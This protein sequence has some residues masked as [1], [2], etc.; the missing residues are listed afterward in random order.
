VDTPTSEDVTMATVKWNIIGSLNQQLV[1]DLRAGKGLSSGYPVDQEPPAGWLHGPFEYDIKGYG[2]YGYV[3]KK[4]LE[5]G[6]YATKY[7]CFGRDGIDMKKRI[8]HVYSLDGANRKTNHH[9]YRLIH[10]NGNPGARDNS[11]QSCEHIIEIDES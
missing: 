10:T 4:R 1:L 3:N 6:S 5:T 9:F 7:Y 2:L 11:Y 8:V